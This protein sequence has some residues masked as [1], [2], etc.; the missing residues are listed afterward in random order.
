M[1]LPKPRNAR[2]R[3]FLPTVAE[4]GSP[5][6]ERDCRAICAGAESTMVLW[7]AAPIRAGDGGWLRSAAPDRVRPV[8]LALGDHAHPAGGPAAGDAARTR[9][10]SGRGPLVTQA[11]RR[12]RGRA[13]VR[14][15]RRHHVRGHL[16]P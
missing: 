8:A 14:R 10:R 5:L 15:V 1:M 12:R 13:A 2:L 11:V 16:W 7:G 6:L 3:C 9:F 4:L